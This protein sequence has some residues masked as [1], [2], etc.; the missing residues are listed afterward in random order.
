[1]KMSSFL[2]I[3]LVTYSVAIVLSACNASL[4]ETNCM[5]YSQNTDA[6]VQLPVYL[7][8]V[9]PAPK[10]TVDKKCYNSSLQVEG[11]DLSKDYRGIGVKITTGKIDEFVK[12]V[13]FDPLPSR[14][15]LIVDGEEIT[16]L[17][18]YFD[19]LA[20]LIWI[21]ENVVYHSGESDAYRLSWALVLDE[22]E[23]DAHLVILSNT[24]KMFEYQ[25]QFKIK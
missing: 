23:H 11:A 14:I 4:V 15:K 18:Y 3:I 22:G 8:E 19:G 16:D 24:G 21:D 13:N 17:P 7:V 2:W 12:G 6:S 25:W 20:E 10:S 5:P 1:M 9:W